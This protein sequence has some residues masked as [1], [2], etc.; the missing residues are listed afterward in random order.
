M[1]LSDSCYFTSPQYFIPNKNR[2]H[3]DFYTKY[4]EK[5]LRFSQDRNKK[6]FAHLLHQIDLGPVSTYIRRNRRQ[7]YI[8]Q[9]SR[10]L[11]RNINQN[12]PY[13][14]KLNSSHNSR[15]H[16][17]RLSKVSLSLS[18]VLAHEEIEINRSFSIEPDAR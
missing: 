6:T 14:L 13:F 3:P 2:Y 15:R 17:P 16:A 1:E 18:P 8:F 7:Y 10:W 5:D 4:A 9:P 12:H 11:G